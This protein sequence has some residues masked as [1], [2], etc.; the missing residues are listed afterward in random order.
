MT[1]ATLTPPPKPRTP[2]PRVEAACALMATDW[3]PWHMVLYGLTWD[4]YE[5]LLAARTA[6]DRRAMF[7]TYD[8]GAA[9][10][11]TVGNRHERLKKLLARLVETA[12]MGFRV[13]LAGSGGTT[14]KQPDLGRGMEP[15]ECFYVRDALKYSAARDL[16]LTQDAPPDLA[17]E[18]EATRVLGDRLDILS[19]LGVAEVWRYDGDRLR[20]LVR[21]ADGTYAERPAGLAF[22]LLTAD[23]LTGYLAR[24]GTTDD[25]TLCLELLDWARQAAPSA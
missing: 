6:A 17:I 16:D 25:T 2:S 19:A 14:L 15:D 1:T 8:Q 22:P 9:E 5:R 10:I 3:S 4:D 7:I 20:I 13:P 24:V 21:A 11:M 12:S 23:L 18:I